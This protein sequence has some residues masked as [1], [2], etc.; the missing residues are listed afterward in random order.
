[1]KKKMHWILATLLLSAAALT[2]HAEPYLAVQQGYKCV[3]CHVNPTG[4]GMRNAFGNAFALTQMPANR[5]DTDKAWVGSIGDFLS[6]GG[7]LRARADSVDIKH[8]KSTR[9][10]ELEQARLYLDVAVIPNRLSVYVDELVAPGT[11]SNREAY[12]RYWTK[13]HEWYVKAGQMYLP[14]GLRLQ[15]DT[16]FIRTTA[17]INMTTPDTGAE[18]GFE[19]NAWSAQLAVSNGTAGGPEVDT[20]KQYSFQ[21]QFVQ[22]GYRVGLAANFNDAE[23]GSRQAYGIFTGIRTGP[24]A[25]LGEVD[26]VIDEGTGGASDR[27]RVAG[28]VEADWRIRQGHNLKLTAEQFDPNRDVSHDDQARWSLVYEYTPIQFLQIRAGTRYYDGIPQNDLQ[29]RRLY[30]LELHGFF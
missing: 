28:L 2:A 1:M 19:H 23:L 22:S 20:G 18:I 4:G 25:W 14:F 27:K 24:V 15:D 11:A 7:D 8:Q 21:G 13:D 30:F 29:N 3:Q 9:E 6:L 10:F 5:I 12:V 17:N 26:Y 16:A